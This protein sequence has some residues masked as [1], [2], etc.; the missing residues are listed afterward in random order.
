MDGPDGEIYCK[1]C[2]K[3]SFPVAETPLIYADTGAIRPGGDDGGCP[4][5][6]GAVFQVSHEKLIIF[7][8][9]SE[10]GERT[11]GVGSPVSRTRTLWRFRIGW[12]HRVVK[13]SVG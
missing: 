5:C 13:I 2:F 10:P 9:D 8:C 3:K 1:P 6:G 4:R 11:V 12:E 7:R